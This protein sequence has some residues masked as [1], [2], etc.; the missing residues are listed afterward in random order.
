MRNEKLH[1]SENAACQNSRDTTEAEGGTPSVSW[2]PQYSACSF[3]KTQNSGLKPFFL[4]PSS[5]LD[6]AWTISY[7]SMPTSGL[8]LSKSCLSEWMTGQNKLLSWVISRP[9]Q[10][11]HGIYQKVYIWYVGPDTVGLLHRHCSEQ[12]PS[13]STGRASLDL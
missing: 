12:L 4:H 5:S 7:I 8:V 3:S 1:W 11:L 10:F 9:N 2:I 6:C 13:L